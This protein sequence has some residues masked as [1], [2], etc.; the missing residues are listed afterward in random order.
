MARRSG[1]GALLW[2]R[3]CVTAED[4]PSELVRAVQHAFKILDWH[5]HLPKEEI[6]PEWMWSVDHELELWFERVERERE[7]NRPGGGGDTTA[8]MMTNELADEIR[9]R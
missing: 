4:V 2:P 3:D 7:A 1:D 8:E 6:P 9:G 5:E